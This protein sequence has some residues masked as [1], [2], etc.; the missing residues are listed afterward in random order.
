MMIW[1]FVGLES[2]LQTI[3]KFG[4]YISGDGDG[5]CSLRSLVGS[6]GDCEGSKLGEEDGDGWGAGYGYSYGDGQ[7][8]SR[9]W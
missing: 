4:D 7:C 1:H 5:D 8:P 6:D 2:K 3:L 9:K